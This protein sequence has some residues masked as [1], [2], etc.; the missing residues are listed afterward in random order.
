M[1]RWMAFFLFTLMSLLSVRADMHS[2]QEG[3]NLG[4]QNVESAKPQ[5][6]L[7]SKNGVNEKPVETAS[8]KAERAG[9]GP[10]VIESSNKAS[11]RWHNNDPSL[12]LANEVIEDPNLGISGSFE[13]VDHG[14][15]D[16]KT[17]I[18]PLEPY[19]VSCRETLVIDDFKYTPAKYSNYWCTSGNHRPD[20]P[21]CKS[22]KYYSP[23]R[24]YQNEKVEIVKS[25][26]KSDCEPLKTLGNEG[27]CK[28]ISR[29]CIDDKPQLMEVAPGVV[30]EVTQT[31]WTYETTYS[32]AGISQHDTCKDLRERGCVQKSSKAHRQVG[33]Y[34]VEY[35]QTMECNPHRAKLKSS[36]DDALK[37]FCLDG[38][39]TKV[40]WA[41][42]EDMA[43]ALSKIAMLSEVSKNM[44]SQN[45]QIFQGGKEACREAVAGFRSCCG[46]GKGWGKSFGHGCN[47]H[48]KKLA[49]WRDE[50]K[51]H[52]V[53][54][55]CSQRE[56]ITGI[57]LE[58]KTS[59][60][61]FPTK[62]AALV[63]KAGH[64]QLGKG[65]GDAE[66]PNCAGL[67]L[68]DI[69]KIDFNKIDL[70]PLLHEQYAKTMKE[71]DLKNVGNQMKQSIENRLPQKSLS[72]PKNTFKE[73][74]NDF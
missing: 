61:C 1:P 32:C 27:Y 12:D 13:N 65:W 7:F 58:K 69:T 60:C 52:E 36:K 53:G 20:N 59:F 62:M 23:A 44:D 70:T 42:N 5:E 43:E 67:S 30:H 37:P 50:N 68:D 35:E 14:R 33:K 16:L 11:F 24:K 47:E 2:Y 25:T 15:S 51:C 39:C 9:L 45:M 41:P 73:G 54:T 40:E 22:K 31:C 63:Q 55:Y 18:E 49:I 21:N 3:A 38:A 74:R 17:C 28:V 72:T 6:N 71:P 4:K 56:K 34:V 57:C 19:S 10:K 46:S 66:H 29:R 64:E 26:W 8:E 48:E